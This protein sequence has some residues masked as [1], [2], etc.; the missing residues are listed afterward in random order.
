MT[1]EPLKSVLHR[2]TPTKRNRLSADFIAKVFTIVGA[3]AGGAWVFFQ[4]VYIQ[5]LDPIL[6]PENLQ[7]ESSLKRIGEVNGYAAY[8]LRFVITNTGKARVQISGSHFGATAYRIGYAV[9]DGAKWPAVQ[10]RQNDRFIWKSEQLSR[11]ASQLRGEPVFGNTK[12]IEE[13]RLYLEAADIVH[14]GILLDPGEK[15]PVSF[16]LF[17][18]V[19]YDYIDIQESIFATKREESDYKFE[20]RFDKNGVLVDFPGTIM[21]GQVVASADRIARRAFFKSIQA[22]DPSLFLYRNRERYVI[23]HQKH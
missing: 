13:S 4:F 14:D 3:V 10:P 22:N 5:Y 15:A 1:D 2:N 11:Q 12:P 23:L 21:K 16:V 20:W 9:P 8:E 17:V 7:I 6:S 19:A 18:P